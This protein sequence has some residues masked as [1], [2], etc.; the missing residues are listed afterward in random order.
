M[1]EKTD[2]MKIFLESMEAGNTPFLEQLEQEARLGHVPVIRRAEQSALK[3]LLAVKKPAAVL[4]IGTA[5]GFS[6]ILMCTYSD[7]RVTTIEN[8]EKRIPIARKNFLKSGFSDRI[9]FLT[10]D[11]GTILPSLTEKFDLIFMDAAKGQYMTWLT[12]AERLLLP[13]GVLL[14]DNVLQDGSLL[15][16]HFAVERRNRTI[17]KR[18]RQYLHSITDSRIWTTTILPVG[19]G[20]AVSVK[21]PEQNG[22]ENH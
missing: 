11:A 3:V 7:A 4:E 19:D 20:L 2:R 18:M 13:G 22:E 21:C 5:V 14:S 17:Y 6:A 1:N 9:T 15:D 16:S 8:Y 10:G 12:E